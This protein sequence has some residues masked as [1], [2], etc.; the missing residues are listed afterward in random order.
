MYKDGEIRCGRLPFELQI[1]K[2]IEE[3]KICLNNK[4]LT[5]EAGYY[6]IKEAISLLENYKNIKTRVNKKIIKELEKMAET[7]EIPVT[8]D[9]LHIVGYESIKVIKLEKLKELVSK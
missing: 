1:D 2:I 8:I 7:I 4:H 3:L 9:G 5:C 6:W